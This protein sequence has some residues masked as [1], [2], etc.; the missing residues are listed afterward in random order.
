MVTFV[1]RPPL[2]SIISAGTGASAGDTGDTSVACASLSCFLRWY[3]PFVSIC[4]P[5][6]SFVVSTVA[7]AS[8]VYA[9][10][11]I[12]WDD[13]PQ[14]HLPVVFYY[15]LLRLLVPIHLLV[16]LVMRLLFVRVQVVFL[17]DTTR[18][19]LLIILLFVWMILGV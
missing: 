2:C 7:S 16:M 9:S 14:F 5:P 17:D 15:L 1:C 19:Y 4:Q 6:L 8:A 11:S 3:P 13:T 12:F 10:S 18:L